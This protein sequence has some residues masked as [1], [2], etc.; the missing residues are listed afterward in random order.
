M[1]YYFDLAAVDQKITGK[2]EPV[3]LF[4]KLEAKYDVSLSFVLKTFFYS[5]SIMMNH[6]CFFKQTKMLP[7]FE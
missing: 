2:I 3:A 1:L 4:D 7:C 5:M 6:L